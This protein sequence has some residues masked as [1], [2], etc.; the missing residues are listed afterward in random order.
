MNGFMKRI[1]SG[2]LLLALIVGAAAGYSYHYF[3]GCHSGSCPIWTSH[4][5][6]TMIGMIL[7]ALI[8]W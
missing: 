2:R 1:L 6:S 3:V 5:K 7:A 8:V 4:F